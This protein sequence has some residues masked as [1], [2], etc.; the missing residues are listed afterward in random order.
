V[1]THRAGEVAGALHR[2]AFGRRA[3]STRCARRN[4]SRTSVAIFATQQ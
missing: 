4:I 2:T 3:A 1:L